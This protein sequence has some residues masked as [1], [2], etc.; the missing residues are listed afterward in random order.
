M[1][2]IPNSDLNKTQLAAAVAAELGTSLDHGFQA[3]DAVFGAIAR[4][5]TVTNFGSWHAVQ[6]PAPAARNPQTGQ[7]VTV[8]ARQEIRV[9]TSPRL[10][11]IVRGADPT[12]SIRKRPSH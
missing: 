2:T 9:L 1:T 12:V 11:D 6:R 7:P 3:V 4:T 8:P 5:V 10:R